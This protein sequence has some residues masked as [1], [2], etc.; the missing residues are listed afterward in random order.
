[1]KNFSRIYFKVSQII[2]IIIA[3]IFAITIVGIIFAI[4]FFFAAKRFKKGY[5]AT[6]KEL[7]KMKGKLLGWGIFNAIA[8]APS[9]LDMIAIII[10]AVIAN[11]CIKDVEDGN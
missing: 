9:V 5:D 6:D 1:M 3:V 7:I 11:D 2:D 4:P 8:L 10:C